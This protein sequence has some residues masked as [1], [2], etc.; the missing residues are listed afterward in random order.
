MSRYL[1]NI[2]SAY[3]WEKTDIKS[4]V[5]ILKEMFGT[6]FFTTKLMRTATSSTERLWIWNIKPINIRSYPNKIISDP[7]SF[8][9]DPKKSSIETVD[10]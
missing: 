7:I 5:D 10:A 6:W 2:I 3:S 1:Q 4:P 9:S 8:I